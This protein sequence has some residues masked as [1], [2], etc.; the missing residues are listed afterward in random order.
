VQKCIKTS[1]RDFRNIFKKI[2]ALHWSEEGFG[3]GSGF[4]FFSTV[5]FC[6]VVWL[7]FLFK[8]PL[9][10]HIDVRV[11]SLTF[12]VCISGLFAQKVPN[13]RGEGG[14]FREQRIYLYSS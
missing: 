2:F 9:L 10:P 1:A 4:Y 11:W 5:G 12:Y 3:F 8:T 6:D 14:W 7:L 13:N